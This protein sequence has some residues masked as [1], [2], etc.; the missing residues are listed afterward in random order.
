MYRW[1]YAKYQFG[2]ASMNLPDKSTWIN[3][4]YIVAVDQLIDSII[5]YTVNVAT[6][7][8]TLDS[9]ITDDTFLSYIIDILVII[10][11]WF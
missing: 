3:W 2:L 6:T 9:L 1:N 8:D 5:H 4:D 7:S 10:I 11:I